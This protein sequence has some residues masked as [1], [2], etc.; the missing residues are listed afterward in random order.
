MNRGEKHYFPDTDGKPGL[1]MMILKRASF[2]LV[3]LSVTVLAFLYAI[4]RP[5]FAPY[6]ATVNGEKIFLADLEDRLRQKITPLSE[7]TP[8][9][10]DEFYKLR[11]VALDSLILE[12]LLHQRARALNVFVSNAEID[13]AVAAVKGPFSS[14]EF[15][16]MIEGGGVNMVA[17]REKIRDRLVFDKLINQEVFHR[18][19]ISEDEL[20][21][22]YLENQ[23]YYARSG[24]VRVAQ[25]LVREKRH[26]DNAF[27]QL[28]EGVPFGTV[29]QEFSVGPEAVKGGDMGYLEAGSMPKTFDAAAFSLPVGTT[30]GIIKT[31]YGYH[32]IKVVARDDG[33][34]SSFERQRHRIRADL[35]RKKQDDAFQKWIDGIKKGAIIK[36]DEPV[37]NPDAALR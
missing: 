6:V 10:E 29:A 31:A 9:T 19:T 26:A 12:R 7:M 20:K 2:L 18:I 21:V 14:E 34:E 27:R 33:G 5:P 23:D 25:I 17:F 22:H 35:E 32:I 13:E 15:Q 4:E 37:R 36:I 16:K 11:T 30:S 28:K 8:L 24:A 1:S 3:A